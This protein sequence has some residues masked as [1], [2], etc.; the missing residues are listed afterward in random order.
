LTSQ[1]KEG[2]TIKWSKENNGKTLSYTQKT[3]D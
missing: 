3:K 2:Q 1:I